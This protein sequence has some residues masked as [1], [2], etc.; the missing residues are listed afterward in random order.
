[1]KKA[2][3]I[4]Q[5][6]DRLAGLRTES[7]VALVT[8]E[9]RRGLKDR[10]NLVVAKA[11]KISGELR[12][13][14][15]APD[16]VAAFERL[17]AN[18]AKLDKRCAATF[19]IAA[20]LYALDYTEPDVYLRG[21]RHVQKEAS[22][23]PPVDEAAKLRAQCALGLARTTHSAALTEVAELLADREAHARVGAIRALATNGGEAGVMLLR[24][25]ALMGDE[26]PEVLAECF[27]GLLAAD[28]GRSLPFVTKFMD[29][30]DEEVSQSAIL[31]IGA[32][33]RVEAFEVLR[34]KWERSVDSEVRGTLLMAMAMVRVEEATD[35][36][37]ELLE[38]SA[39][40]TA[41]E[42]VKVLG[43][44]HREDRVRERVK[45]VVEERGNAELREAVRETWQ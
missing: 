36:L 29:D 31:A 10:S 21:I 25:K 19:E 32:Q 11:A 23:G 6:L 16:L 43:A 12:V 38:S 2:D 4:E 27:T 20:T 39:T 45:K 15:V 13:A 35:F 5:A 41:V 22:F 44:Y 37:I 14:E 18:P 17:M 34:E 8:A 3:P 7:D 26:D 42:V 28:F 1:M 30:E 40:P 24:Y 33:R 9:L